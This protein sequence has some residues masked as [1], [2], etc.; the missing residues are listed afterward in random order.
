[1]KESQECWSTDEENFRYDCLD[2]LLDSN[3][4]LEVGGVVYVGNAKH[5]KPEQLCD[6]DD[7]IDRISDNAWDIGG[8]YA[9]DYPNVTREAHQELDDF[10]KSWIMKHCPPNFYQVFDVREH[11]LTEEDLKK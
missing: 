2:D 4:D 7:I 3:D 9:E 1:M 8:E 11:V 6:A 5:P 10:I